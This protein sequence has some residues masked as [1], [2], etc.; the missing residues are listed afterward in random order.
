MSKLEGYTRPFFNTRVAGISCVAPQDMPFGGNVCQAVEAA[1][2]H[3]C[4]RPKPGGSPSD[5]GCLAVHLEDG[6]TKY[7]SHVITT[8]TLPCLRVMNLTGARLD[9]KQKEALRML[10]YGPST[11]IGVRFRRRWWEDDKWMKDSGAYG[12][13][14]G[15]QSYTDNMSRTVVYPSYGIDQPDSG[16]CMIVS[17]AWTNDA[18]ALTALM[19]TESRAMLTQRVLQD[20]V[21]VHNFSACAAAEL[22]QMLEEIHPYSWTTDPNTMGAIP[23]SFKY[24]F[25]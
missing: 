24:T 18:L 13:I 8:T 20:L 5:V 17:Y 12:A 4:E 15:G 25:F 14:K 23:L 16:A 11:K 6:R 7:Y 22:E 21:E 9:W 3:E 10:Q 19:G 1:K 2:A